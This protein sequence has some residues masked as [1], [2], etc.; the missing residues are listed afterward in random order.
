MSKAL[1][2]DQGIVELIASAITS[3]IESV[4]ELDE[5]R[6]AAEWEV[7]KVLERLTF[8]VDQDLD[9]EDQLSE[10]RYEI[11]SALDDIHMAVKDMENGNHF[12]AEL[13]YTYDIEEYYEENMLAC[14]EH[15][16]ECKEYADNMD[17]LKSY[18]VHSALCDQASSDVDDLAEAIADIDPEDII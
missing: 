10:L 17:E 5:P 6:E 13:I 16:A 9:P 7:Q 2:T 8:D 3:A 12:H 1:P 14:D 15:F 11:Q 18:M 4:G